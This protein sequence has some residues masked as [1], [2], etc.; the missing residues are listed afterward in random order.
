MGTKTTETEKGTETP[1]TEA[2][3]TASKTTG[4]RG[5]AGKRKTQTKA[6]K[7]A[8]AKKAAAKKAAEKARADADKAFL[9]EAD[10]TAR[11][12]KASLNN[13][14][15][16]DQRSDDL[17]LTAATELADLETKF[18]EANTKKWGKKFQDYLTHMGVVDTEVR[19]RSWEN[20]RKLLA[21]GRADDPRQA[22]EDLRYGTAQRVKA[23]RERAAAA[24]GGDG[25]GSGEGSSSSSS[26]SSAKAY[27]PTP[28]EIR[29][30]IGKITDWDNKV[31]IARYA[32]RIV[33]ARLAWP[34]YETETFVAESDDAA[35]EGAPTATDN[36]G[37]AGYPEGV[38]DAAE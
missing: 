14:D 31:E 37:E 32:A 9:R 12:A 24:G 28:K 3:E 8:A 35:G 4:Q 29:G 38:E 26:S 30:I 10:Q 25:E 19:G 6:Q 22:L 34:D 7:E 2:T 33:G 1:E 15:K 11:H 18:K 20:I 21:V 5:S 36:S 27:N 17:R 23:S 13:A 16:A